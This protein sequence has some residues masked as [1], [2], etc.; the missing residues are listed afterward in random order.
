MRVVAQPW[1][2]ASVQ[3]V[4]KLLTVVSL[5]LVVQFSKRILVRSVP[6]VVWVVWVVGGRRSWGF[7]PPAWLPLSPWFMDRGEV[8]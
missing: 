1:K 6:I 3:V 4:V 5:H 2:V 8:L 7:H